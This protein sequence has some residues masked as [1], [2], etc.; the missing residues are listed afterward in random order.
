MLVE[1]ALEK[2][3]TGRS[4]IVVAHRLTTVQRADTIVVVSDANISEIGSHDQLMAMN[5][6]YAA[7]V[8]NWNKSQPN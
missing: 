5:G 6:H 8:T 7:L 3:M 2:L 1:A 4:V